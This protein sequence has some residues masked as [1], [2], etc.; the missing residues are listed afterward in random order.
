L[1]EETTEVV[2]RVFFWI[3]SKE[4]TILLVTHDYDIT[5]YGNRICIMSSGRLLEKKET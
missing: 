1:D 3:N 5:S 4:S 2:R